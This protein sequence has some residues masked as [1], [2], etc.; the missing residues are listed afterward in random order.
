MRHLIGAELQAQRVR[1]LLR[2]QGARGQS[3]G[4]RQIGV[5]LLGR[6][7]QRIRRSVQH[8][9]AAGGI[10]QRSQRHRPDA[11]AGRIVQREA[12]LIDAIRAATR[13]QP[14]IPQDL[15]AG[16]AVQAVVVRQAHQALAIDGRL[17]DRCILVG[18]HA[19]RQVL[20][21]FGLRAQVGARAAQRHAGGL[22][23]THAG[24]VTVVLRQLRAQFGQDLGR[25]RGVGLFRRGARV[26]QFAVQQRAAV[27]ADVHAAQL[28]I[29]GCLR[30]APVHRLD[31][32]E[33]GVQDVLRQI[34]A[35]VGAGRAA[36]QAR[37]GRET[38]ARVDDQRLGCRADSAITGVQ[39]DPVARDHRVV[40]GGRMAEDAVERFDVDRA[41]GRRHLFQ[42]GPG[43]GAAVRE[44]VQPDVVARF[45]PG[46]AVRTHDIQVDRAAQR[47]GVDVDHGGCA[48]RHLAVD[49]ARHDADFAL[50]R[51][52]GRRGGRDGLDVHGLAIADDQVAG[53]RHVAVATDVDGVVAVAG[54]QEAQRDLLRCRNIEG[55]QLLLLLLDH[56][57]ERGGLGAQPAAAAGVRA[58][59]AHDHAG[60]E[61]A[62]GHAERGRI[63][64]GAARRFQAV[65][66]AVGA[67]DV[68]VGI[69]DQALRAAAFNRGR[70][71]RIVQF[72]AGLQLLLER[73]RH[74]IDAVVGQDGGHQHGARRL[75][76]RHRPGLGGVVVRQPTQWVPVSEQ[77]EALGG[78]DRGSGLTRR[79]A[80]DPDHHLAGLRLV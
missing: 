18:R 4:D 61:L 36:S 29:D 30:V 19:D 12:E 62:V 15:G 39:L 58:V 27:Q 41:R 74:R 34:D 71:Q 1:S 32:R 40:A 3:E 68:A 51:D 66:L 50:H 73:V 76:D 17:Q 65:M 45:G 20:A 28:R 53:Q 23:R 54:A 13:H 14:Q 57:R 59:V 64:R 55:E 37:L 31:Q 56:L 52:G 8:P 67:D 79:P 47:D 24:P 49:V 80:H 33:I 48:G 69:L 38:L 6:S 2:G 72:A 9:L 43:T 22:Q 60:I 46:I 25:D 42:R 7:R 63:Q 11:R 75:I 77:V 10:A 78:V 5:G 70:Q 16:V 35:L 21:A 44:V 26:G